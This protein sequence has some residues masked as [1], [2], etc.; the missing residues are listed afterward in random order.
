MLKVCYLNHILTAVNDLNTSMQGRNQNIITPSG[1]LS[2]FK[3][4]LQFWKM[5][6]EDEQQCFHQ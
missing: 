6:L 1:K 5:K 3:A 4:K 2:V